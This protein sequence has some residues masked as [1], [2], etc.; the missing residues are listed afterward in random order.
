[1]LI[2]IDGPRTLKI[3]VTL[4]DA[5]ALLKFLK[6]PNYD[7]IMFEDKNSRLLVARYIIDS[8]VIQW[9]RKI[10]AEEDI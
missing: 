10:D 6:L 3:D 9:V 2:L 7:K 1:M 8:P 5:T 4:E